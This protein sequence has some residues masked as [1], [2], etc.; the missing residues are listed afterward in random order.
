MGVEGIGFAS[1][2]A[3]ALL[4]LTTVSRARYYSRM[5]RRPIPNVSRAVGSLT[6]T[7]QALGELWWA[8]KESDLRPLSYQDSVLP[9]NYTRDI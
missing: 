5:L 3:V 7:L 4:G 1:R 2:H 9:L 6:T 8:W